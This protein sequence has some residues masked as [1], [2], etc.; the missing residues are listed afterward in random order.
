QA[1]DPFEKRGGKVVTRT[2][3]S[4]GLLGG[5]SNGM[6]IIARVA[7]KP[8]SSIPREQE[9]IEMRGGKKAKIRVEGRHDPCVVPRAVPIV[10]AMVGL[11]LADHGLRSGFVPRKLA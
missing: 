10:E 2:N 6:P 8:A 3:H 1:N 9:T 11:V 5:I 4:G 7:L